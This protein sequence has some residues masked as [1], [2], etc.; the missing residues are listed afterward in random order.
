MSAYTL[1]G[2]KQKTEE[3][4]I[5][6]EQKGGPWVNFSVGGEVAE[7]IYFPKDKA[8]SERFCQGQQSPEMLH[9]CAH[10]GA[11]DGSPAGMEFSEAKRPTL[12]FL[13]LI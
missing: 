12:C 6:Q 5:R 3:L 9:V 1:R 2:G 4:G 13:S 8:W 7:L 11:Y 10:E